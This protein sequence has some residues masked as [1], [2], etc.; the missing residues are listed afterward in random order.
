MQTAY[1]PNGTR[2]VTD[3]VSKTAGCTV[4]LLNPT[5]P[6][7]LPLIKNDMDILTAIGAGMSV[8]MK[9]GNTNSAAKEMLSPGA[10]LPPGLRMS[11]RYAGESSFS[12]DFHPE[13]VTVGCGDA[14]RALEYSVRRTGNKTTLLIKDKANPISLQLMADGSV[15]GQGTVQVNG[16]VITGTTED[17]NSPFVF[18]PRL[19][20]CAVGRLVAGGSTVNASTAASAQA[21]ASLPTADADSRT[22][23]A[24]RTSLTVACGP[25]VAGLLAGKA[26]IV[27][28]ESLEEILRSA[29]ISSQG[30]SS[31]I[32]TWARAC[33]RSP[34]EPICQQGI[35]GLGNYVAARAG[36]DRNGTA[37][38]NNVPSLGTFYVVAD[39]S[40]THHLVWNV[41]V[42]LKPGA[43]SIIL[44]ER[45]TTPTDR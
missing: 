31:R 6:S 21:P 45:N 2:T 29:G 25:D 23:S 13:S 9:G 38:F 15:V 3:F 7:P 12:L 30:G 44:D 41:R 27:L 43:N 11:G 26:L 10:A 35:N 42:D 18:A 20:S 5:G 1:G 24:G 8:L 17:I 32:S 22:P 39:T 34:R 33:E 28:K 36:F 40:Y 16:R 37:A 4:G 19:A 14:E